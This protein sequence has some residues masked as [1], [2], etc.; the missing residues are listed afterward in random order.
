[1]F[2]LRW[3]FSWSKKSISGINCSR[4]RWPGLVRAT[5]SFSP[6]RA[7]SEYLQQLAIQKAPVLIPDKTST[8]QVTRKM[9]DSSY[10]LWSK[11]DLISRII[12]LE[13]ITNT[14]V[15]DSSLTPAPTKA[16]KKER[17]FEFSSYPTR[18]I[19]IRFSYMG[20]NYQG[21]TVQLAETDLPT[22][23]GMILRALARCRLI[24]SADDLEGCHISRCGRTDRGVSALA[25]VVSIRVRSR[26]TPEEQVDEANDDKEHPYMIIL[27]NSLPP[28]IR[29][30][31]I[32]LHPPEGFDARHSC[33]GRHYKYFFAARPSQIDISAMTKGAEML[34]GEHDFRNFCKIDGSK[35]ITNYMRRI[36]STQFTDLGEAIG[37]VSI[38]GL[39][40]NVG[41]K[42]D[43]GANIEVPHMY[44]FDLR[45]TAF[46]WHQVRCIMGVLFLVG[47]G[48][49]KPQVIQDLLDVKR[50]PS[51]PVYDMAS[52]FPLV[53]YNCEYEANV[54][55]KTLVDFKASENGTARSVTRSGVYALW[56]DGLIKTHMLRTMRET[57]ER[58]IPFSKISDRN[59]NRT[60]ISLGDGSRLWRT[61]Y[62]PVEKRPLSEHYE[63]QNERFRKRKQ[64][65]AEAAAAAATVNSTIPAS[66]SSNATVIGSEEQI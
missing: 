29:V 43:P 45:G 61:E 34:V 18:L 3:R 13:K 49:E 9:K 36:L 8:K 14:T 5:S 23:E 44:V 17:E 53:L 46:L 42:A 33:R 10:R 59:S 19:A 64:R 47:D 63:V 22:V 65:V 37:P 25:Q 58:T 24:S 21:L 57:V 28:D 41:G 6:G 40:H 54:K 32:C 52:D 4:T 11:R 48:H 39:D 27:N 35:Q 12:E 1:M 16:V 26:L 55:W 60:S 30:H 31:G 38:G 20:W 66:H 50:F 7:I 2:Y 62:V 51:R 15:D 56:Y